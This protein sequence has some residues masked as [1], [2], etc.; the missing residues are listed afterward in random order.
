MSPVFVIT[1]IT[2]LAM[3]IIELDL[4]YSSP[5]IVLSRIKDMGLSMSR[6]QVFTLVVKKKFPVFFSELSSKFV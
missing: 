3:C 2:N 4:S 1:Y 6:R 5:N